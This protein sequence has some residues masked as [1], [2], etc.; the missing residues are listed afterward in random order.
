MAVLLIWVYYSAQIFFLGAE[1]TREFA[2]NYGSL[3]NRG[4]QELP[5]NSETHD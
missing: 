4:H 5:P 3:R 2:L 1:I